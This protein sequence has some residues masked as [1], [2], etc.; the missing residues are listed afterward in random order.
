[1]LKLL[2]RSV[3]YNLD[4][5]A[6]NPANL[7]AATSS[8]L[9]NNS[10][11]FLGLWG[12]LFSGKP[13]NQDLLHYYICLNSMVMLSWGSLNFLLGGYL[14]L[15]DLIVSGHFESKLAAPRHPLLLVG[16]HAV[17]PSSLGDVLMGIAG[18]ILLIVLGVPELALKTGIASVLAM[19]AFYSLF[20]LSGSLAFYFARGNALAQL[21]N[22]LAII[23]AGYPVAKVFPAGA[24]RWLMLVSPIAAI[25]LFPMDW[26]EKGGWKLFCIAGLAV[27]ALWWLAMLV[28]RQGVK[29]FQALNVVGLQS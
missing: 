24:G 4:A 12:M 19:F 25:T 16:I 15:G 14:Q 23:L 5:H 20:I 26:V 11:F 1:M 28:Y 29:R 3:R 18:M 13:E 27:I 6:A 21:L 10:I 17:E 2:W 8:M 22:N 7:L 9:L